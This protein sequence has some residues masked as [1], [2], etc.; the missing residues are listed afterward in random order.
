MALRQDAPDVVRG[1]READHA[2]ASD[3]KAAK[4]EVSV[5]ASVSTPPRQR[6][7]RIRLPTR[8]CRR[9]RDGAPRGSSATNG[10]A[11]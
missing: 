5:P 6:L 4:H 7:A 1:K 8:A 9:Q 10:S 3:N 2:E 11:S